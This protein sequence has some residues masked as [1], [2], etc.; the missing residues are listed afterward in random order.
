MTKPADHSQA[1]QMAPSTHVLDER[2]RVIFE[3]Q[4]AYVWSS[5][6]RLGADHRDLDDLT[7]DVFVEIYRSIGNYDPDRPIRPWLFAFAYRIASTRRRSA[8]QRREVLATEENDPTSAEPNAEEALMSQEARA[9][10]N[11]ALEKIP[12]ARRAVF[13]LYELDDCPMQ[14]IA[15]S[16]Q[17]PLHT[18]Y[19]RL[20]AAREEFTAAVRKLSAQRGTR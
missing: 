2:F 1:L 6:R 19:S 16:L 3:E 14:E 13:V 17:I 10:V 11:E 12:I 18:A 15:T 9:I 20:R 4:F 5:L 7:H 8:R